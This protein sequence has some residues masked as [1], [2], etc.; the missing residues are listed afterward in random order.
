MT[1]DAPAPMTPERFAALAATYGADLRRW[2]AA[3]RE[4]ARRLEA[5]GE[6]AARRALSEAADLD[7]LLAAWVLPRPSH[8]LHRSICASAPV[9]AEG[10]TPARF[11]WPGLGLAGAGLAGALAGASAIALAAPAPQPAAGWTYEATAFGN[12]GLE[13]DL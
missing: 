2:P 6:E 3:E 10:R 7:H 8:A 13:D 11:W 1:S 12:L 4:A 9:P 5:S